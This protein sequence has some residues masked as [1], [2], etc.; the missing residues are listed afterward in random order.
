A[1]GRILQSSA[2]GTASWVVPSAIAGVPDGTAIGNTLV[3]NGSAWANSSNVL[4]GNGR[5]GIGT[6]APNAAL[7]LANVTSNRRIVLWENV[8]N[9]HQF[10]GLGINPSAFRLQVSEIGSDFT[11]NAGVTSTTSTELMRIK[12]NGNVGIG[13]STPT[14]KLEVVGG[15]VRVENNMAFKV[16]NAGELKSGGSNN[17]QSMVLSSGQNVAIETANQTRV[18]VTS[19]GNVGVG[20]AGPSAKLHVVG[21]GGGSVDFKTTGRIMIQSDNAG[22]VFSKAATGLSYSFAGVDS[23]IPDHAFGIST[24]LAGMYVF[25]VLQN[26]NIGIGTNAPAY[27]L[28]VNGSVAG[29]AAYVNLSDKRLKTNV[30]PITDALNKV[31]QLKGISFDW[32]QKADK[33]LELDN[34]NHLGFLAQ[35]VEKVLP[36]VVSTAQDAMQTKSV[37]YSDIVPVLVEAL[38]ELKAENDML[39]LQLQDQSNSMNSI[40]EKLEVL[41]N[42]YAK[43]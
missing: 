13:T 29:T 3:W 39:K 33:T 23:S 1:A 19:A 10:F 2:D 9:D 41:L 14:E 15:S 36:Q 21:A 26:G 32:N 27:T 18:F 4:I 11:F 34:K 8:N 43:N 38:K 25:N 12:G 20:T 37:A 28:H 42:N 35:E 22:I 6:A 16:T 31:M 17:P 7:Q 5:L 40:K 30:Q 24:P